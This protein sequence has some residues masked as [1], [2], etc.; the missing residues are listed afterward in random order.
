M[1]INVR[2]VEDFSSRLNKRVNQ[3]NRFAAETEHVKFFSND[4][5]MRKR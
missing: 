5:E 1:T 3:F 4:S 2:E